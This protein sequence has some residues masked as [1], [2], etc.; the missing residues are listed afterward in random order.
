VTGGSA[1]RIGPGSRR[2]TGRVNYALAQVIG[3]AAGSGPPN[4]FT[5]IGRHRRL[6]RRWLLFAGALMP[7][8]K[9]PRVDAELLIVRTAHLCGCEYELDHHRR[10]GAEAGLTAEQIAAAEGEWRTGKWTPRQEA[11][12]A[13]ADE[14]H[15]DRTIGEQTWGALA[16]L[17][18]ETERIE[19]CMLVGHY[20]MLAMTLNSLGT[21]LDEFQSRPSRAGQILGRVFGK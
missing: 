5:T 12:L 16:G 17:T 13:A 14:L 8:G 15:A 2:D 21:P 19:L 18:S 3:L 11:L 1:P 10:L 6:F 4:V 20:E 9:L 7:G